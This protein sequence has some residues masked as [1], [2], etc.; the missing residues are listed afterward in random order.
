MRR[1]LGIVVLL[2]VLAAC[3]G[4]AK[5]G[6]TPT[7]T[8]THTITGT[9]TLQGS[10]LADTEVEDSDT[11]NE[12]FS[13]DKDL[14][15]AGS[16]CQGTNGY[17]DIAAGLQVIVSDESG[18]VIANGSLDQGQVVKAKFWNSCEFPFTVSNVPTAKFYR[19]EVGGRGQVSY[20]Y[21]QMGANGWNVKLSLG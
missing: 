20:S 16:G 7:T 14:G 1:L 13:T 6:T 2:L 15:L 8:E 21:D 9:F 12:N 3:A 19:V 17:D 4:N 18:T 11:P 10:A 5:S